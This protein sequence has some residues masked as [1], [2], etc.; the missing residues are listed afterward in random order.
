MNTGSF[1]VS[2]PGPS[3]LALNCCPNH[4]AID[5]H[6]FRRVKLIQYKVEHLF[7]K[8]SSNGV[9]R[10]FFKTKMSVMYHL[11]LKWLREAHGVCGFFFSGRGGGNCH[12]RFQFRPCVAV[13]TSPLPVKGFKI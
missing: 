10:K 4:Y 9:G 5:D 1:R 8:N 2:I 11:S 3:P 6:N 13:Y 12:N 7:L